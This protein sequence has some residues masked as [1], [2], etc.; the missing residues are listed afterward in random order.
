MKQKTDPALLLSTTDKSKVPS[1]NTQASYLTFLVLPITTFS[2]I[3]FSYS[4]Y[5]FSLQ[6]SALVFFYILMLFW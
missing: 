3:I 4:S 1:R 5:Y 2:S 6:G